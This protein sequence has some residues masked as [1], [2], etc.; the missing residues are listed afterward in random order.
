MLFNHESPRRGET[1]V[2]RKITMF[3]ARKVKGFNEILKL[4]NIYAKR[5]WGHAKDYVEMQ[6]RIMQQK[7]PDDYVI[8]TGS[9]FTVK[10]FIEEVCRILKIKLLWAGKGMNERA[11][12]ISGKKKKLLIKVD[13]RYFRPLDINYLKGDTTKAKK[14]LN[15]RPK[16][17]FK[18]LVK[19]MLLSDIASIK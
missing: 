18:M 8:A 9:T 12:E 1:F 19:E 10:Q 14:L 11:Y 2:T 3:F 16:Y 4:G 17:N 15:Y 6:W 5:D 7:K 13:K